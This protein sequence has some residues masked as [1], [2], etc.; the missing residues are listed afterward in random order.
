MAKPSFTA[1]VQA[2]GKKDAYSLEFCPLH[3]T[4]RQTGVGENCPRTPSLWTGGRARERES[5]GTGKA[6]SQRESALGKGPQWWESLWIPLNT[7]ARN[8]NLM[9]IAARGL[10]SCPCPRSLVRPAGEGFWLPLVCS[11][12]RRIWTWSQTPQIYLFEYTLN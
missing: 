5:A 9:S 12:D 10:R 2:R 3:G 7:W 1:T 11:E 8:A 4:A 6:L